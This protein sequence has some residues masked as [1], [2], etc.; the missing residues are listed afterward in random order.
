LQD[1]SDESK[2]GKVDWRKDIKSITQGESQ[3]ETKKKL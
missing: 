2:L 3:V 1:L